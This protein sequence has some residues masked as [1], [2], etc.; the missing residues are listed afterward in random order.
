MKSNNN[1]AIA[2]VGIS[3]R[4]PNAANPEEF[5]NVLFSEKDVISD[6][7]FS[8]IPIEKIFDEDNDSEGKTNQRHGAYLNDIH[9]FDPMFFNIS[10]KE[11]ME[12]HPSQKL[13]LELAWECLERSNVPHQTMTG[14][15]TGV[16]VGHIWNDFEHF[17]KERSAVINNFSAIGQSAN[18]IASR[19]SYFMGLRGPSFVVDTG[20]SSS[21]VALALA[22]QGLRNGTMDMC[23]TGGINHILNPEQY[24][25][26]SK[27]G[28]LSSN[29][30]CSAFD[31]DADG[32]VRAEG[33]GLL[34][35]KRLKDAQRDKNHI[36]A[37]IRGCAMNNNGFNENLPATSIDGQIEVLTEAYRDANIS[38]KDIHYVE[39]HGTG[40]KLGDPNEC[41]A[42]GKLMSHERELGRE[43]RV[44]SV[45]TN[46]GHT[47]AA[48][49][50]AG[51]LKVVLSLNKNVLPKN[52]HYQTPNPKID[53]EKY[54]IKI[55]DK[56]EPWPTT[57]AETKKAGV[58]SFG[59][60]GT[61]VH[62]VIEE[63]CISSDVCA[64]EKWIHAKHCLPISARSP[65]ALEKYLEQ[66]RE[67]LASDSAQGRFG[68][69]CKNV[70]LL[71]PQF[72][73]RTLLTGNSIAEL[74]S[75]IDAALLQKQFEPIK[76]T[77]DGKTV[78][79]FPGQGSQW[80]G[81]GKELYQ[82]EPVFKA[83]IDACEVAFSRYC[84]WSLRDVLFSSP[85]DR[86]NI[87][88]PA[89]CA[90]QIAIARLWISWGIEP[91][92]VVGH[93]MGEV[94]AAH[95][96]GIITLDEAACI[97]CMR[98]LL[99]STLS[100]SGG[101]MIL[102]ELGQEEAQKVV[103][104]SNG[105]LCI[106]V[107]NSPKSTVFAGNKPAVEALL[108]EMENRD[109][110]ARMVKVDV[111]SHSPQM[112]P[113]KD[114]L[115][116]SLNGVCPQSAKYAFYSTVEARS[117][118]GHEMH[119][120][121]WVKNLRN[122]V[123]FS[124]VMQLLG[125][126]GYTAFIEVSPHP[127][128]INAV[129]E[130][131]TDT[132]NDIGIFSSIHR[133]K[134]VIDE[135]YSN[136]QR[137]YAFGFNPQWRNAYSSTDTQ[138][139]PLP[140][141]PF[142]RANYEIEH[143][144]IAPDADIVH[145]FLGKQLSLAGIDSIHIWENT[146]SPTALPLLNGHKVNG[147]A[148]FPASAYIEMIE[149]AA[150][151]VFSNQAFLLSDI[152]FVKAIT[153]NDNNP[154]QMQC[155]LETIN[156]N[157][158]SFIIYSR[159]IDETTW[160]T[161]CFGKV[162][163]QKLHYSHHA[164]VDYSMSSK[165]L[166][167]DFYQQFK[168]IGVDYDE[169]F[170]NVDILGIDNNEILARV[171][172]N[173][174]AA[175]LGKKFYDNPILLDNLIESAFA[176]YFK[177]STIQTQHSAYVAS[178]KNIAQYAVI[179]SE[180]EV[181]VTIR[182]G[183]LQ[184]DAPH[185][186]SFNASIEAF[187]PETGNVAIK[188]DDVLC[189]LIDLGEPLQEL[190]NDAQ[191]DWFTQ[192]I[193]ANGVDR[194]QLI[195]NKIIEKVARLIKAQEAN[196]N[197]GLPFKGLGVDSIMGVQLRNVLEKEFKIKLAVADLY[198]CASLKTF[199]NFLDDVVDSQ[200]D[201]LRQGLASVV[202]EIRKD[203]YV[204]SPRP[205]AAMRL[206]CFHDA[207]GSSSL[208]D[209][210]DNLLPDFEIFCVQLPGRGDL[211][212]EKPYTTF[213]SFVLNYL[214]KI[215]TAIGDKPFLL[216]GHSMGGLL[217]FETARRLQQSHKLNAL[218]LIITGTPCL[219]DF[220]NHFVINIIESK[221]N[222]AQLAALLPNAQ[223]IDLSNEHHLKMIQTLRADFELI[224]S[225]QYQNFDKLTAGILAINAKQDD[226]V[227][228]TDVAKWSSETSGEFKLALCE[229]EHHFVYQQKAFVCEEIKSWIEVCVG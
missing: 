147:N 189:K 21:M 60:G 192:M 34:L 16:Y 145:P 24:V 57:T 169:L 184:I 15:K 116:N 20:C 138:L 144:A 131:F 141:Y 109:L 2:I 136:L 221:L 140:H 64:E 85:L 68:D 23:Y 216:F 191:T 91:D 135:F 133:E 122:A 6:I 126:D 38:L 8:R 55:Q 181:W 158:A 78:F 117:I 79:I 200:L 95:I 179:D 54:P 50:I 61:N 152:T 1:E 223:H 185:I 222:D 161:N 56:T 4:F 214:P 163:V 49:G 74:Q 71:R 43:L 226:R 51:I 80:I 211:Y 160:D 225:Y 176:A 40:T 17:R 162:E 156:P 159:S 22:I 70:S 31:A 210:W 114:K 9:H 30:R 129:S 72:E 120:D 218:G 18:I 123:Q 142:M 217:A 139:L 128:L 186:T 5:W 153:F 100:A 3:C 224:Y 102:T 29:G 150:Q 143:R 59:W 170:Q 53:F 81:M 130:N 93:S 110:F 107:Q 193:E 157:T 208:F 88:Q 212:N 67:Y 166:I 164:P 62:A 58:S 220:V 86:I 195:Q 73:Y 197:P 27:F 89:I 175:K 75:S 202:S 134:S 98:S 178:I 137:V 111:A 149:V 103:E 13:M 112:D 177:R 215:R 83:C 180:R 66:Y 228:Q 194:K 84:E 99:M 104:Q 45:K 168:K 124:S 213:D 33:A 11:A 171:K 48:A 26:L 121:Y 32:F 190:P 205:N 77:A 154:L 82:S 39:T 97:I 65:Q 44:G 172:L 155:K 201:Q 14:S 36:Y 227:N 148:V 207:G 132:T 96:A 12:M 19:I 118:N 108:K 42:L 127:V 28:G 187:Y 92:A 10:P 35:L 113:I 146:L 206:I 87:I 90:V 101:A 47:E 69:V 165:S 174:A 37:V 76:K 188:F 219:R 203:V 196:I 105:T 115:R 182:V 151:E 63:Y 173:I 209:E 229:G 183:D 94:A 199:A 7:P 167:P 41:I 204:L 198:K 46:F 52:L 25:Y 125:N 106:A 119:A